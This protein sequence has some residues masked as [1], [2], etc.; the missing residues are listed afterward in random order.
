MATKTFERITCDQVQVGDR[1]S[2]TR[3]G[4]FHPVAKINEGGKSRRLIFPGGFT[5]RPRRAAKLWREVV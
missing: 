2:R 1:I 4:E 5:I 3:K